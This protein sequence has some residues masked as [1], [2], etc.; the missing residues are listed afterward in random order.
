MPILLAMI[1]NLWDIVS[2]YYHLVF[3]QT[4]FQEPHTGSAHHKKI[5][6]RM[7]VND[8]RK[9]SKWLEKDLSESTDFVTGVMRTIRT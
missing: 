9:V 1:Q 7:A 5:I 3:R 4:L 2:P 6:Q 8:S